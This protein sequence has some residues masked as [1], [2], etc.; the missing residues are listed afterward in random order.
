MRTLEQ[1]EKELA[2]FSKTPEM[3][4][5]QVKAINA[6]TQEDETIQEQPGEN[7]WL[8]RQYAAMMQTLL[9]L[10]SRV[11]EK[12]LVPI[13]AELIEQLMFCSTALE[14]LDFPFAD[15]LQSLSEGLKDSFI[16]IIELSIEKDEIL[17]SKP[18]GPTVH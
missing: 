9:S 11:D 2:E 3:L 18:D 1:V 17:N 8:L 16:K 12:Q 6:M 5:D 7:V 10:P 13:S 14:R 15:M 4:A